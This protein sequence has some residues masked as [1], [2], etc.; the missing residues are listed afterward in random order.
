MTEQPQPSIWQRSSVVRLFRWLFSWRGV[1]R[2][3]IV[4]AWTVTAIALLYGFENWR[5][6]RAWNKTRHQ[7]EARGEVL[8]LKAFIPEP[9]SPEQNFAATPFVESW[10]VKGVNSQEL[11]SDQWDRVSGKVPSPT[12]RAR[13]GRNFTDLVA[14]QMAFAALPSGQL[15][16][17]D[18]I[19]AQKLDRE[20]RAQAAPAVLEGLRAS[21]EK[22]AELRAAST[23]PHARYPVNYKL[24]DPWGI[25]LPHLA[26]I[27]AACQRLQLRA[28]AK[29][30]LGQTDDALQDVHLMLYMAD[31]LKTEPLLI[32]HLVRVACVQIAIQP[33]WE[34]LAE[35]RWS[36][37]QLHQLQTRL[38]QFDFLAGLDAPLDCERAAAILTADLLYQQKYR[39]SHLAGEPSPSTFGDAFVD[40]LARLAPRGWYRQEQVTYCRIYDQQRTGTFDVEKR[41]VFPAALAARDQELQ[42]E[43]ARNY[44]GSVSAVMRHKLLVSLLLPALGRLPLRPAMA[45]TA[46]DQ[47]MLACALERYRL[48]NNHYPEKLDALAPQFL[49]QL[50][51]DLLSGK[52]YNYRRTEDEQFVLYSV[53]WNE[54][55]DSGVPGAK[56]YDEKEG[57]WAWQ[58]SSK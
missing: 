54:K 28:C 48:A 40:I 36:D 11:W 19:A 30:A 7:L 26:R 1:R 25:L 4:L 37:A 8:D 42:A 23:R 16:K 52:P 27:K 31:T 15:D 24:D 17:E 2:I 6:W 29:L 38:Q 58:Y 5:G 45:Q 39:L 10:F 22:L 20:A 32:S 13:H 3:L 33:I 50:P 49:S 12:S 41:R 34:G 55:D 43:L 35:H 51:T 56:L 18:R 46:T 21:E 53:G 47:A 44:L 9:V 57:D 14:W